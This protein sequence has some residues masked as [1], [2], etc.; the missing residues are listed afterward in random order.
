MSNPNVCSD[1]DFI[2]FHYNYPNTKIS[3]QICST[4]NMDTIMN[5]LVTH[6]MVSQTKTFISLVVKIFSV[7]PKK[8]QTQECLFN[9][10]RP[11]PKIAVLKEGRKC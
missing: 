2:L 9:I 11:N 5:I 7:V 4:L 1:S 10:V 6:K 3:V 8:L